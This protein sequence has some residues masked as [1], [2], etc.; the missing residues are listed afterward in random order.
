MSDVDNSN[1]EPDNKADSADKTEA[2]ELQPEVKKQEPKPTASDNEFGWAHAFAIIGTLALLLV[3]FLAYIIMTKKGE[4]FPS[5]LGIEEIN[6]NANQYLTEQAGGE[7]LVLA[8]IERIEHFIKIPEDA[9]ITGWI[10]PDITTEHI[11]VPVVYEFGV[12]VNAETWSLELK[13]NVCLAKGP[14]L[15]VLNVIYGDAARNYNPSVTTVPKPKE[16]AD[17]TLLALQPQLESRAL[18]LL[19]GE[20]GKDIRASAKEK[21]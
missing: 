17:P 12:P 15:E 11:Q 16:K 21:L 9:I 10:A 7:N 13:G 20:D 3:A 19:E 2:A 1:K 6:R 4:Q 8:T 5:G 14:R 18:M